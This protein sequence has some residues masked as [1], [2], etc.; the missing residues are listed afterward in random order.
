VTKEKEKLRIAVKKTVKRD[1]NDAI[2]TPLDNMVNSGLVV[3]CKTMLLEKED[4]DHWIITLY[5]E[6][7]DCYE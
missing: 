5:M 7:D 4:D 6:G 2:M 1:K 3:G